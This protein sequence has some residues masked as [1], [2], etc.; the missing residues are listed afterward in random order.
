MSSSASGVNTDLELALFRIDHGRGLAAATSQALAAYRARPSVDAADV[1]AWGLA[2]SGRCAEAK[3]YSKLALR[4]GTQDS[5]KFFHRGMI[6]RC[7]G[8]DVAAKRWLRRALDLNPAFLA[9]VVAGSGE[10]RTMKRLLLLAAALAALAVPAIASAH[11]LGNFT[12]NHSSSLVVSGDRVY[13]HY[14]LDMAEIPTLQSGRI[15][16]R[17]LSRKLVLTVDGKRSTL[18]RHSPAP[19][20]SR[21]GLAAYRRRGSKSCSPGRA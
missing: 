20:R 1:V 2:R 16:V 11:P 7:L 19:R 6:E 9:A 4:L 12:I 14:V 13:V 15:D 21:R 5:L 8:N 3:R 18:R 10:A 17:S